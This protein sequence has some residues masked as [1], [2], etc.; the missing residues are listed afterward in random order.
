MSRHQHIADLGDCEICGLLFRLI[1]LEETMSELQGAEADLASTVD[2]VLTEI[3]GLETQVNNLQAA[4]ASG[5]TAM[6]QA[7]A[8]AIEDQ[9]TR[10]KAVLPA[11]PPVES[12]PPA[13]TP[14]ATAPADTAV[15]PTPE[16]AQP[17]TDVPAPD[18]SG[19]APVVTTDTGTTTDAAAPATDTPQSTTDTPPTE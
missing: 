6:T 5:D 14:D 15:A 8:G 18:A 17:A 9:V 7:A 12:T 16:V 4:L 10:L 13:A 1:R 19:D 2:A 11:P 3:G